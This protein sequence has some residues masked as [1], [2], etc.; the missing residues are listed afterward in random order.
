MNT[1]NIRLTRQNASLK[2]M[3]PGLAGYFQPSLPSAFKGINIFKKLV[4]F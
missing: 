4:D 2:A 3:R 1:D